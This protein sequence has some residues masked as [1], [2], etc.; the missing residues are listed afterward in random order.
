MIILCSFACCAAAWAESAAPTNGTL[1]LDESAYCRA[2]YRFD[3]QQISPRSLKAEGEKV[4]GA[5][6]LGRLQS[7]LGSQSILRTLCRLQHR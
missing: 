4:L 1:I 2:Y 5:A 3:V 7:R 6:L